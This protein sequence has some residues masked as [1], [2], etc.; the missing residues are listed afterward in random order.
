MSK[1]RTYLDLVDVEFLDLTPNEVVP[2]ESDILGVVMPYPWG[3]VEKPIIYDRASFFAQY[4]ESLPCG[5]GPR[6]TYT[7]NGVSGSVFDAKNTHYFD[8]YL[9]VK[10]FFENGGRAVEVL[11][12][13]DNKKYV[14]AF[15]NDGST[16]GTEGKYFIGLVYPGIPTNGNLGVDYRTLRLRLTPSTN[17]DRFKVEL[18]AYKKAN[19]LYNPTNT[20][21]EPMILESFQGQW[22]NEQKQVSG[23]FTHFTKVLQNSQYLRCYN[24][25]DEEFSIISGEHGASGYENIFVNAINNNYE[26]FGLVDLI[27]EVGYSNKSYDTFKGV[28]TT[29]EHDT[30]FSGKI[31]I[32]GDTVVIQDKTYNK[33]VLTDCTPTSYNSSSLE[34][35]YYAVESNELY[36]ITGEVGSEVATKKSQLSITPVYSSKET[37]GAV[38]DMLKSDP[39]GDDAT[40]AYEECTTPAQKRKS[41]FY[42]FIRNFANIDKT[43]ATILVGSV[44]ANMKE[45]NGILHPTERIAQAIFKYNDLL[46]NKV[47]EYCMTRMAFIPCNG[48]GSVYPYD[49]DN[50]IKS[51][52]NNPDEL[53][54][55]TN[56][57][58]GCEQTS[59]MGVKFVL[60]CCG[61]VAGAYATVA[62]D[63]RV[64]Q[65]ASAR[66]YGSYRGVLLK[67][68]EFDDVLD[69]HD[70]GLVTVYNGA[71]GPE[72]FGVHSAAYLE[73][74]QSYYATNN[75]ARVL[76]WMLRDLFPLI[77]GAIHTDAVANRTTRAILKDS[78]SDIVQGYIS[79]GNLLDDSYFD[80]P[81]VKNAEPYNKKGRLLTCVLA[82]HFIGLVE[83]VAFKIV[84]TD[85]TVTV[86]LA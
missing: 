31:S 86:E 32:S 20:G 27:N 60:D 23:T 67:D 83:R 11:C 41:Y 59:F 25:E 78:C 40:R 13:Q 48:K 84:A 72:I 76:T 52:L 82:C 14:G 39:T 1:Q 28:D 19:D 16:F 37:F 75:V 4:P 21:E 55:F 42:Q 34:S 49:G 22:Y 3:P 63:V 81:E 18:I 79:A 5:M 73:D 71:A 56:L 8:A 12:P 26:G 50:S 43:R 53:P 10:K 38:A 77:L 44:A 85:S 33:A 45:E 54:K 57:I 29:T 58:D 62:R 30:S 64:N 7:K 80:L 2:L 61:G 69:N 70:S 35:G 15:T 47:A 68:P 74:P 17:I 51:V 65:V 66:T 9:Q 24:V 36:V 6:A 46:A